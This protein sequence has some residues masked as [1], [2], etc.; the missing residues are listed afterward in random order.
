MSLVSIYT[1]ILPPYRQ[2]DFKD[3]QYSSLQP[4]LP[5]QKPNLGRPYTDHRRVINDKLFA[6]GRFYRWRQQRIWQS[7][8]HRL[9]Q[10]TDALGKINWDI[11][12]VDGS[13][14]RAH[15]HAA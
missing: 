4:L 9:Q 6:F 14:V 1:M 2:G 5:P 15:Q 7:I 10:Q 8:L 12:F 11:H 3:H 13:V